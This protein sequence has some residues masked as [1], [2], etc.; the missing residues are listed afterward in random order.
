M[1]NIR[2]FRK[3]KGLTAKQLGEMVGVSEAAISHYETEKRSPSYETLLKI[4]EILE[5]S[6][7]TLL[8]RDSFSLDEMAEY[9]DVLR[10]SPER[11]KLL[12]LTMWMPKDKLQKLIKLVEVWNE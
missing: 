9:I 11:R 2:K 6:V 7:D 3:M 4:G 10:S 5:C 12:D 1:N 8:C